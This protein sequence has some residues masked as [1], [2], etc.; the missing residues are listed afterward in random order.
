[1]APP[2]AV[3][4]IPPT[5]PTPSNLTMQP[6]ETREEIGTREPKEGAPAATTKPLPQDLTTSSNKITE[7]TTTIT[8]SLPPLQTTD[9]A[10]S[11]STSPRPSLARASTEPGS[12]TSPASAPSPTGSLSHLNSLPLRPRN[13]SPYARPHLRSRSTASPFSAPSM[14]R[15]HTSPSSESFPFPGGATSP[16]GRPASPLTT[17]ARR[18]SPLRRPIDETSFSGVDIDQT[19][20]ENSEL[21]LTPRP[22]PPAVGTS[23]YATAGDLDSPGAPLTPSSPYAHSTFPRASARRRPSSPLHHLLPSPFTPS[24]AGSANPHYPAALPSVA[25]LQHSTSTP[26]LRSVSTPTGTTLSTNGVGGGGN[27]GSSSS[28]YNEAPPAAM[29]Y[30]LSISTSGGSSVPSTP[31]SFRSRSPSISSLE[32]IPDSPDAE[33]EAVVAAERDADASKKLR[34]EASESAGTGNRR[35]SFEGS[36][37]RGLVREGG[38]TAAGRERKRWSVCGAERR[39]DLDLETIWED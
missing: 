35:G 11:S 13:R 8:I 25:T 12:P 2:H 18:A 10:T 31:T 29:A 1:M 7:F 5:D 17:A 3:D 23:A 22:P 36:R 37:G 30:A 9:V 19:I 21:N 16:L 26:A 34:A 38:G 4:P 32:T 28:R 15:A 39:G 6:H 33:R 20:A 24:S 14:I 27:G